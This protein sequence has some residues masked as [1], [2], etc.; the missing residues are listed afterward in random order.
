MTTSKPLSKPGQHT[1]GVT[2]K[3]RRVS[4]NPYKALIE[5]IENPA[6]RSVMASLL[7]E[8]QKMA[9]RKVLRE[10]GET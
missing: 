10:D 7:A 5:R 3:E 8:N 1:G 9:I 6:V 2:R 4:E